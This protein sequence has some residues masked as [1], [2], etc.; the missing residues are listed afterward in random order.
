MTERSREDYEFEIQ[1]LKAEVESLK[2]KQ[3]ALELKKKK[4]WQPPKADDPERQ[5]MIDNYLDANK[6]EFEAFRVRHGQKPFM[7]VTMRRA[8][9][10]LL[11]NGCEDAAFTVIVKM[12]KEYEEL[13]NHWQADAWDLW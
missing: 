8:I 4:E 5:K 2:R 12:C 3:E 7:C 1:K 9:Q 13:G 6:E 11:D 10:C